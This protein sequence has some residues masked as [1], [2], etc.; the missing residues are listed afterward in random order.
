MVG[1]L[2]P[3]GWGGG[4]PTVIAFD[5]AANTTC[6]NCGDY[7]VWSHTIGAGASP[8]LIV[9]ISTGFPYAIVS[10]VNYR[11]DSCSGYYCTHQF[12]RV[13]SLLYPDVN[14]AV[15]YLFGGVLR[16]GPSTIAVRFAQ[17]PGFKAVAG[18]FS[19][20]NVGSIGNVAANAW[21][22]GQ[23]SVTV[24]ANVGEVVVDVL[25]MV[26]NV[27]PVPGAGQGEIWNVREVSLIG[28]ASDK[29]A[30]SP[31][32]MT[33]TAGVGGSAASEWAIIAFALRPLGGGWGGGLDEYP[34]IATPVGGEM[35][36]VDKFRVALPWLT[37][38]GLV[39]CI[40]AVAVVA[41]K[42]QS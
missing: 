13:R 24:D 31:V 36:T 41:K 19:Y 28:A 35:L 26:S 6:S 37:V 3:A 27:L 29:P 14:L 17:Y 42:R 1:V 38:V 20:F 30:T 11:S 12:L 18:S 5:S 34:S 8:F 2:L 10:S 40:S 15:Y 23:A 33:W 7:L 22:H 39:G 21:G 16:P 25:A 9:G 32:T 4:G